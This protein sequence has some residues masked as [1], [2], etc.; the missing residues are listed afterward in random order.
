MNFCPECGSQLDQD[1]QFCPNC[2][3]DLT[4]ISFSSEFDSN[5]PLAQNISLPAQPTQNIP[6]QPQ[7]QYYKPSNTEGN[8]ALIFGIIGL[9]CL[10]IMGSIVA[11]ILGAISQSKDKDSTT[12]KIGLGLGIIGILCWILFFSVILTTLFSMYSSYPY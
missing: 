11:I 5:P 6:S 10:P 4:D 8:I 2:G 7:M 9:C 1:C 12:G 3:S